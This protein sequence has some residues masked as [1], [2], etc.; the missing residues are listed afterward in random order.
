MDNVIEFPNSGE[1]PMWEDVPEMRQP[2]IIRVEQPEQPTFPIAAFIGWI[3][4]GAIVTTAAMV[5]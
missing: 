4:F 1:A 2:I 5:I 3:I